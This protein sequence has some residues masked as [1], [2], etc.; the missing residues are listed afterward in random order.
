MF[1][2][3]VKEQG[4]LISRKYDFFDIK[5]YF[6]G[7]FGLTGILPN[8]YQLRRASQD[9]FHPGRSADVF[10]GKEKVASFGQINPRL[11]KKKHMY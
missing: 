9:F 2:W 3:K 10:V 8:R 1:N 11:E 5:G 7:I 6:E 4:S